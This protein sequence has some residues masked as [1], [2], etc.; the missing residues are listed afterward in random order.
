VEEDIRE[1]LLAEFEE[2]DLPANTFYGNGTPIEPEVME[3]LRE[4]YRRET[5]SF[6]WQKGDLLMLDNMLVAHGRAPYSGPRQILVGMAEPVTRDQ[7]R[8]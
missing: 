8:L 6:P 2:S 7:A 4:A 3:H 5:V 1:G